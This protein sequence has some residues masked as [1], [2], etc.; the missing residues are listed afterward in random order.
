MPASPVVQ[1]YRALYKSCL[2]AVRY[3][4]PSRIIVR[5][6]LRNAFRKS[7]ASDFDPGKITNTLEFLEGAGRGIG[8]EHRIF[9]NLCRLEQA[10]LGQLSR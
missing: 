6:R 8:M 9:K 7:P 5:N 3:S 4:K 10:R 1:A 2:Y